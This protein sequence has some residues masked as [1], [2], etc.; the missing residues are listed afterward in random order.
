MIPEYVQKIKDW[1]VPKTVKKVA[2][3]LGFARHYRTFIPQ[4]SA[5]M[6]RL[7]RIKKAE[8]FMWNE[9][10]WRLCHQSVAGGHRGLERTLNKFLKGFFMLLVRQ[11]IRVLNGGCYMCLTKEGSMPVRAGGHVQSLTGYVGETLYVDLV[12]MSE[13]IRGNQYVLMAEDSFS[14]Y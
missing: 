11:K 8:K 9:E 14:R 13:T 2:T 5:L 12:F 3:F 4:Y 10:I 7:N 1:P 6:I